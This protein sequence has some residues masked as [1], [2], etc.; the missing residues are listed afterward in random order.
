MAKIPGVVVGVRLAPAEE[1]ALKAAAAADQRAVSALARKVL[2]EWL[3]A[4][5][6][7]DKEEQ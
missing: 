4:Q 6:R 3:R 2:V 5:G 1:A 7:L